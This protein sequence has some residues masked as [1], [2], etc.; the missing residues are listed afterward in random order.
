MNL[1]GEEDVKRAF[2]STAVI[3]FRGL[4]RCVVDPFVVV[5][6]SVHPIHR[7]LRGCVFPDE[8]ALLGGCDLYPHVVGQPEPIPQMF[9]VVIC[10]RSDIRMIRPYEDS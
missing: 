4:P 8:Q 6:D 1:C 3:I 10:P 2:V 7:M 9:G 5:Q